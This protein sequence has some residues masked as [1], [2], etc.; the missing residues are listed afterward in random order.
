V[1]RILYQYS[2][3]PIFL[4]SR[5]FE[6]FFLLLNSLQKRCFSTQELTCSL[7]I[8]VITAG[9]E[10]FPGDWK[11][12]LLLN[13]LQKRCFSTQELICSFSIGFVTASSLALWRVLSN[14][15]IW[16]LG[17][18]WVKLTPHTYTPL[19]ETLCFLKVICSPPPWSQR[20]TGIMWVEALFRRPHTGTLLFYYK[21]IKQEIVHTLLLEELSVPKKWVIIMD[22]RQYSNAASISAETNG[23]SAQDCDCAWSLGWG[24]TKRRENGEE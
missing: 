8:G 17:Y 20:V 10:R 5:G 19:R 24:T 1:S 21:D 22:R 7:S 14:K 16:V 11:I 23:T 15:V 2:E 18:C 4:I 6:R 12:F 3:L 13:S 9:V